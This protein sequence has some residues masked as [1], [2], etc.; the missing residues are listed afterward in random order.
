M[1]AEHR[2]HHR[3]A[4]N[5]PIRILEGA[6]VTDAVIKN[7]SFDGLLVQTHQVPTVRR[8]IRLELVLPSDG[9]PIR[10]TAMA[11]HV[12]PGADDP[13]ARQVGI[14][15]FG[16]DTAARHRWDRFIV[17]LRSGKTSLPVQEFVPAPK[18]AEPHAGAPTPAEAPEPRAAGPTPVEAP[19]PR[20]PPKPRILDAGPAEL[21]VVLDSSTSV[22]SV[23]AFIRNQDELMIRT[24]VR[25]ALGRPVHLTLVH[26][27][28]E[29][30]L[31]LPGRVRR[32]YAEID[33]VGL[34]VLV[35]VDDC[36]LEALDEFQRAQVSITIEL[37]SVD[38]LG[39]DR[40]AADT[41]AGAEAIA[42]GSIA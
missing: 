25:I 17:D 3:Y 33:F 34:S 27:D 42:P 5:L 36:E 24:D 7:V 23:C 29:R 37:D 20:P 31:S 30:V 22:E 19:E 35:S 41:P 10:L 1:S 9:E 4:V 12:F 8:L 28:T 38:L 40:L 11:V 39:L 18:P 14:Q 21:R 32:Q 16:L 26:P 2:R 15:M 13:N 6:K